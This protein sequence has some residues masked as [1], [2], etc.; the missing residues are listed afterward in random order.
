MLFISYT[1]SLFQIHALYFLGPSI[2]GLVTDR[3]R[4]LSCRGFGLGLFQ[5]NTANKIYSEH[6]RDYKKLFPV[7]KVE[8]LQVT[9]IIIF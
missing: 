8:I 7:C 6:T 5:S 2:N 1:C 3:N 9:A 4:K